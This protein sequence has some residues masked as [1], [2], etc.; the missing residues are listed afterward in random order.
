MVSVYT[1]TDIIISYCFYKGEVRV[2][3][4]QREI[5]ELKSR[6][7]EDADDSS[8]FARKYKS[9]VSQ[10]CDTRKEIFEMSSVVDDLKREKEM[11]NEKVR[12]D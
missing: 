10:Q 2:S 7:E 5:H 11:L 12:T 4:L 1:I 6:M 9:L 8:E 3:Q